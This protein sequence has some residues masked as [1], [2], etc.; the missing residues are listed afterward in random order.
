[1]TPALITSSP[2]LATRDAHVNLGTRPVLIGISLA[3]AAGEVVAVI[4]PNGAGKSTLLKTLSGLLVPQQG[5]VQL[6]GSDLTD[7]P[8][9]EIGQSIAYLPQ[10]RTV[11]WPLAAR[12]VVALGRLP[13]RSRGAGESERDRG[14]IEHAMTITDTVAFADRPVSSLSGGERARVLMARALAQDTPHMLFNC[15][16]C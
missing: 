4:G 1:M 11:H 15:S 9:G 10:E 5:T 3:F 14:A 16:K 2:V 13:H 8:A 7:I 12:A 6:N